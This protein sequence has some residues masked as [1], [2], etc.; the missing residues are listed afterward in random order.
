MSYRVLARKWRPQTFKQLVGQSHVL[1]ALENALKQGRIHHAYLLTGTRG[2]GKTTIARILA[3]C[4]NCEEGS[5]AEPCGR[6]ISCVEITEGRS[7]DLIEVDAASRT[8][9]EDTRDLLENS[10][11]APSHGRYKIYL[12]DEV[13]M[14]S[15]HSFNALLKTLEEP[16]EHVIFIFATTHPQKIPVTVLS[17]CLQFHLKNIVVDQI[18]AHLRFV[19]EEEKISFEDAA[20]DMIG[21]AAQGSMRDALSIT[22]QAIAFG[23][24][25]VK[26]EQVKSMLGMVDADVVAAL[27]KAIITSNSDKAFSVLREQASKSLDFGVLVDGLMQ[28]M[29][30]VAL[31]QLQSGL[32]TESQIQGQDIGEVAQMTDPSFIQII[33]QTLLLGKKDL[34]L[35]PD[36]LI[37]V[38]MLLLRLLA[39]RPLESGAVLESSAD[40]RSALNPSGASVIKEAQDTEKKSLAP[41]QPFTPSVTADHG[42]ATTNSEDF[43]VEEKTDASSA[44]AATEEVSENLSLTQFNN[45]VWC[46][47]FAMMPLAGL[48]RAVLE[49]CVFKECVSDGSG[50]PRLLF[51][52][53]KS[54]SD[55][56]KVEQAEKLGNA[57]SIVL[58]ESVKAEIDLIDQTS[59]FETPA[60]Y[61]QRLQQIKQDDAVKSVEQDANVK[62][63]IDTFA[64]SLKLDSIKLVDGKD[65]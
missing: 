38:E 36:P 16:P 37:G 54:L 50:E 56:Y 24:G 18:S 17:R 27:V 57:M 4:F 64:G 39:F 59:K 9:V 32:G 10:Q 3:R 31:E 40:S 15:N 8:K 61:R 28:F 11:F 33:Y 7:L 2:V 44:A 19:L 22:E 34:Q 51:E 43:S 62:K 21:H 47:S 13:H 1:Q 25:E 23:Q 14:L 30:R 5:S 58:G 63:I 35:A 53:E 20:L 48:V 42:V 26:A 46:K 60:A 12:I 41:D 52:L 49:N 45:S 6:C 65:S 29:H 55:L